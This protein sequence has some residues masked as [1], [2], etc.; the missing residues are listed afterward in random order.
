MLKALIKIILVMKIVKGQQ[1][2]NIKNLTVLLV[3]KNG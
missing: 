2:N 3:I 1:T